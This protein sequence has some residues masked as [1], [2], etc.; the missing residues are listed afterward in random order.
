MRDGRIHICTQTR[1]VL[2][3]TNH[4]GLLG[5]PTGECQPPRKMIVASAETANIATY[6]AKKNI[7]NRKP[8]YS[9]WNP[10]TSSD[11]PSGR[12]NGERLQ[13]AREAT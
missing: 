6:S 4:S 8:L 10:A 3:S 12:S 9:V 7:T 11:S 2:L 5:P 13:L 1:N